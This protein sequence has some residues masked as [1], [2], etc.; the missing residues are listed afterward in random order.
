MACQEK[1][2][3]SRIATKGPIVKLKA[4][5]KPCRPKAFPQSFLSTIAVIVAI[6]DGICRPA[7]KPRTKSNAFITGKELLN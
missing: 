4:G 3:R 7:A 1:V 2:R 6:A 5:A